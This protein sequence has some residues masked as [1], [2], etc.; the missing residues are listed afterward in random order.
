MAWHGHHPRRTQGR[1][2]RRIWIAR[3]EDDGATFAAEEP[4]WRAP[5][6]ACACCGTRALVDRRGALYVLYRAATGDADRD[7]TLLT[8]HDRGEH[9]DGISLQPWRVTTC[10]MSSE[11]MTDGPTGVLA[12]WETK[13]QVFFARIDPETLQPSSP[14]S[15]PGAGSRK[16]P[17]LAVNA[18][19]ETI[20]VWAENTGWQ[21]GG[22]L[23]WRI[24]DAGQATR[25]R[26]D[27]RRHPRLELADRRR[28]ARGTGSP[29]SIKSV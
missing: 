19:G 23:A 17:A 10:P 29:S 2:G 14:V 24:F 20:L 7:M 18:Q 9:F 12:A 11:S 15:P 28:P 3:S 1:A 8:S 6:G 5:T 4:A 13:G 21:R 16:H 27:R 26:P 25:A 22:S